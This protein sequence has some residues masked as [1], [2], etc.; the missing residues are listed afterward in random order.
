VSY[1]LYDLHIATLVLIIGMTAFVALVKLLGS[2]LTK[3]Q[4]I[5]W[6]VIV[7]FGGAS[8]FLRDENIIKWK[9]TVISSIISL[10][11]L[12]SQLFWKQSLV[13]TLIQDKV[14]A[15]AFMLR[16]INFAAFLFFLSSAVL[17]VA[18]AQNFSTTVWVNFK[19]F[20]MLAL[21]TCFLVGCLYYLRAYLSESMPPKDQ[22]K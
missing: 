20:G 10:S 4:L 7:I 11:F 13:E 19:L 3:L 6:L 21:N 22:K 12:I 15:P 18:V 5:S 17:N 9:P 1:W 2:K 14:P 16:K 8:F